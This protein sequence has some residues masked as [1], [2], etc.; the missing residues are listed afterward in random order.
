MTAGLRERLADYDG[1][2]TTLLTEAAAAFGGR[3]GYLDDLIA[4]AGDAEQFVSDGSTWLIKHHLE[5]GRA[6]S[7]AQTSALLAQAGRITGWTAMLHLCQSVRHLIIA[8]A[9]ADALVRWLR[10]LLAHDRPFLRAWSLDALCSV[11]EQWPRIATEAR[12][13]LA[14][15]SEDRAASVRARARNLA[16]G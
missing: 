9:D 12:D 11:G 13:A 14:R 10:P 3:P 1:R 7:A 8:E 2:A 15:A 16:R 4:L 6:L 5:K